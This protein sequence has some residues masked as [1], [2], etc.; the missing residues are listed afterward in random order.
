VKE[1]FESIRPRKGFKTPQ[2]EKEQTIEEDNLMI[3]E[4]KF[5]PINQI[6]QSS[7]VK[8]IEFNFEPLVR[9]QADSCYHR[10]PQVGQYYLLNC[11]ET[12]N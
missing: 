7:K 5:M 10:L 11:F 8:Q 2:K 9:E 3:E 12:Y 4:E 6:V 1:N